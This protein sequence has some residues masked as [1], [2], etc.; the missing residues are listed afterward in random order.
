MVVLISFP[1]YPLLAAAAAIIGVSSTMPSLGMRTVN[2]V[3]SIILIYKFFNTRRPAFTKN[4]ILLLTLFWSAYLMRI[5][6]DTSV[7]SSS[8]GQEPSF[9]WI[10]SIGGC[11]IPMLALA[12]RPQRTEQADFFGVLYLTTALAAGLAFF[13]ASGAV[14]DQTGIAQQTGRMRIGNTLNPI[15]LGHLG[16]MLVIL[17]V[18]AFIFHR[19]WR[20]PK[21]HVALLAGGSIGFYLLFAANSRGPVVATFICM[22]AVLLSVEFRYKF[23]ISIFFGVIA[24]SA[25]PM[26][27]YLEENYNIT[28]LSRL[29]GATIA[30]Q[31]ESSSRLD[32]FASAL[33][34][35]WASPWVGYAMEDP[36]T[37]S[38]PHNVIVESYMALG[39]VFG[40]LF[41]LLFVILGAHA[42]KIL[43]H[44][45][46]YGWPGLLFL[47][48]GIGAQFS[49]SLYGA[50]YMWCAM[51]LL[52]SV[53]LRHPREVSPYP[54]PYYAG[55][56]YV[57]HPATRR[58]F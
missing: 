8:L 58:R 22:A 32:L 28:A 47:Q 49:G 46:Q 42:L 30:E 27:R 3:L 55:G 51:G 11:L 36:I 50:T 17:S 24:I 15:S 18:W 12:L 1:G 39:V 9:Y 25:I 6:Y 5:A 33:D 40:T 20:S 10:W 7:F 54:P 26:A 48:Y 43:R 45:P 53:S 44:Y 2:V 57:A 19:P 29:F 13:A 35:F 34:G 4:I 38:Y 31:A 23:I 52:V 56:R 21:M 16:A 14:V 37:A 41:V